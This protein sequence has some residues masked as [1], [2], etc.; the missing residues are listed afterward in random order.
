MRIEQ[1]EVISQQSSGAAYWELVVRA[2][3]IAGEVR[4]GQFVHVRIPRLEQAVL[5]RPFSVFRAEGE[6]LS[7]LYK[8]VGA[9]T[10]AL[11][12]VSAGETLSVMGPMGTGFPEPDAGSVPVLV[13]GGYGVAPL[14]LLARRTGRKGRLFVGAATAADVLCVRD[15]EAY[16]WE[17]TVATEDGSA[18]TKGLVTAA[19]DEWLAVRGAGAKAEFFACGPDGMLRAVGERA[20]ALNRK[21]WLSLDKHMGCGIGAC[22]AC[23]QRLRDANGNSYWGRVCRD[24][25]VFEARQV[26][27]GQ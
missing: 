21:A 14:Y 20:I 4:P 9:G 1:A 24:G 19:L 18:G 25:P 7:I 5:R 27:W 10:R 6:N 2:P 16:G 26:V 12:G 8:T 13:A 23:V 3:S 11:A 17:T 15:F 22:L